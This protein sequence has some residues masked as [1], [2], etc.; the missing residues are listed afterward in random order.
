MK[1]A[2]S[3]P[4]PLFEAAEQLAKRLRMSRSELYATALKRFV[5]SNRAK[6]VKERLDEVYGEDDS[7]EIE[8]FYVALQASSI[9]QEEW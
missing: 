7:S 2:I 5:A 1:P 4:D 8:P 6:G 9:D 3:L